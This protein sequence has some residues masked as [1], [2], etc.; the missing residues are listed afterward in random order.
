MK[1]IGIFIKT[2]KKDLQWIEFCLK[3]IEKNAKE[4]SGICVVTENDNQEINKYKDL[5][6]IPINICFEDI[7]NFSHTCQDGNGYLWMQNIK[8][9]WHKYCDFD[10]VLQIDSDC[11]ITSELTPEF[12]IKDKKW[13]WWV[14]DWEYA[15]LA[16]VHK[17][18][19]TK[20]LKKEPKY[21]HML[22]PGWILDRNSTINFHNWINKEHNCDW[23]DYLL[24]K[25]QEDWNN[26]LED[27]GKSRGSSVYNAY[28]AFL[29]DNSQDYTF[30]NGFF[31]APPIKQ[32]WSW[33]E[34]KELQDLGIN[35]VENFKITEQ[36]KKQILEILQ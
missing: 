19:M 33:G 9:S 34:S 10:A 30:I 5:V 11:I 26:E 13:K 23:W 22:F 12:Y 3:S 4:F 27:G 35:K 16:N 14:R 36:I 1:K 24:N 8:L 25:T 17:P 2:C 31:D 20:L 29:E 32:F 21:E 15:E 18:A 6:S 7:P 28:G